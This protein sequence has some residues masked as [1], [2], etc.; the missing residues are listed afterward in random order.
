MKEIQEGEA[1]YG[2]KEQ[3]VTKA[4]K[5]KLEEKAAMRK[6]RELKDKKDL[7]E[8]AKNKRTMLG[9]YQELYKMRTKDDD[10]LLNPEK[11]KEETKSEVDANSSQPA[12]E[13]PSIPFDLS[14]IISTDIHESN[15]D[16]NGEDD[17]A[18]L[19]V[20]PNKAKQSKSVPTVDTL[21]KSILQR[22]RHPSSSPSYHT[23][24][25]KHSSSHHHHHHSSHH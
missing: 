22:D 16:S 8:S 21:K 20:N 5:K 7:E 11:K 18:G 19:L 9:F 2:K 6:E 10:L 23:H 3:F 17:D 25:H 15:D 4:Y 14:A 13:K 12:V 1:L 24:A